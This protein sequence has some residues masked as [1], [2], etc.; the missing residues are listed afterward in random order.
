MLSVKLIHLQTEGEGK[1]F[2]IAGFFFYMVTIFNIIY[3]FHILLKQFS[4]KP[5]SYSFF[6]FLWI[7]YAVLLSFMIFIPVSKSTVFTAF[8]VYP[9]W[10]FH[11]F[12][13]FTEELPFRIFLF[14]TFIVNM[15]LVEAIS[16]GILAI[17]G[18]LFPQL[19]L[20]VLYVALRG[21][22]LSIV[23]CAS[24]QIILNFLM[25]PRIFAF[26][27]RYRHLINLRLF[28]L[29]G[30]PVMF[31]IMVGNFFMSMPA[32]SF[33]YG[34][35]VVLS[36]IISMIMW[37]LFNQGLSLLKELEEKHLKEEHQRSILE[38][39]IDHLHTLDDEYQKLYR[40]N[41]DTSNHLLALSLLAEQGKYEQALSYIEDLTEL[42][43]KNHEASK[44]L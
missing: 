19:H 2:M 28:L 15:I 37:Y 43:E 4:H 22:T 25:L 29:L 18:F 23:L 33:S 36:L 44:P 35:Y 20:A 32:P 5:F 27:K 10:I 16:S 1:I 24:F 13:F 26:V 39:E 21:N 38:K 42:K 14:I 11:I 12:F 30:L 8:F 40:W 3:P 7:C 31:M 41:H 6:R 17:L 9:L 34:W